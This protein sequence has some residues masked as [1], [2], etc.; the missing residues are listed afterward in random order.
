[1]IVD[2]QLRDGIPDRGRSPGRVR[3]A[4]YPTSRSSSASSLPCLSLEE[5]W[6]ITPPP[7]FT[8]A[9]PVRME[10]SPLENLL[11]EHPSMSVYHRSTSPVHSQL[12]PLR[13]RSVSPSPQPLQPLP[14][15]RRPTV[16]A[17][18]RHQDINKEIVQLKAAQKVIS[19]LLLVYY[20][21]FAS[22]E[23]SWANRVVL[24]SHEY[25]YSGCV[26]F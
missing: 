20:L 23:Q 24:E 15:N 5:S 3:I 11:I 2:T 8:S 22:W 9:G 14:A 10:T 6:Y 16:N 26:N 18:E 4:R 13:S 12:L 7:C 25:Q 19:L 1:M 17:H 21:K